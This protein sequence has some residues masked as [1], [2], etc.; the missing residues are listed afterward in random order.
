MSRLSRQAHDPFP[1]GQGVSEYVHSRRQR[2]LILVSL[3]VG[4]AVLGASA[5]TGFDETC[6]VRYRRSYFKGTLESRPP[7]VCAVTPDRRFLVFEATVPT[8]VGR[9]RR[10]TRQVFV[11]D[12]VEGR[13]IRVSE[14]PEG[15][16]GDGDSRC[17]GISG[18]GRYVL[19]TSEAGNLVPGE[20]WPDSDVFVHDLWFRE[21]RAVTPGNYFST[22]AS[23]SN[24]MSADGRLVVYQGL[25]LVRLAD[26]ATGAHTDPIVDSVGAPPNDASF[27]PSISPNGRYLAFMSYADNLIPD[28]T[29]GESDVFVIDLTQRT[30]LRTSVATDG[31]EANGESSLPLVADTGAVVFISDADNL[32]EGDTNGVADAFLHDPATAETKRLPFS[33]GDDAGESRALCGISP[34]GRTV[35]FTTATDGLAA[36]DQ[37]GASD[38]FAYDVTTGT[39]RLLSATEDGVPA[40]QDSVAPRGTAMSS[41]GMWCVFD[42]I[43]VDLLPRS[44]RRPRQAAYIVPVR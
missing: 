24:S 36:E 37:D 35:I 41:D 44:G 25:G 19:F 6:R 12:L 5:S 7:S 1:C 2:G 33:L 21:T 43:A 31:S 26:M 9:G 8:R 17:G 4:I 13:T 32:V 42:S 22:F 15:V 38:V 39:L 10:F 3:V 34:D 30:I 20:G 29:N 14:S 23:G 11:R 28:D 40:D 16:G 27:A 18:F